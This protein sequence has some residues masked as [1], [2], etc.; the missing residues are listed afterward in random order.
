MWPF[1]RKS[2]QTKL[3][4]VPDEI[5][6]YYQAETK[7]KMWKIWLLSAVTFVGTLIV[8]LL[9][10]WGGRWT[11][12]H[13]RADQKANQASQSQSAATIDHSKRPSTPSKPSKPQKPNGSPATGEADNSHHTT[14]Q[15]PSAPAEVSGG[16]TGNSSQLID[17]GPGNIDL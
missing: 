15:A 3:N 9:I 7:D 5:R 17:T 2:D 8:V 4:P 16:A 10:F 11:W 6:A 14:G 1:R 13:F 12:R